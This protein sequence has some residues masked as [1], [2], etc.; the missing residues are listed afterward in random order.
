MS[1][2]VTVD[3]CGKRN[4]DGTITYKGK[5]YMWMPKKIERKSKRSE[6]KLLIVGMN[7]DTTIM[8]GECNK[9]EGLYWIIEE[10]FGGCCGI[11][12]LLCI[13]CTEKLESLVGSNAECAVQ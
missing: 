7:T 4:S 5:T 12:G 6:R 9:E 3:R 8:C 10:G 2:V 13:D 11:P 1:F